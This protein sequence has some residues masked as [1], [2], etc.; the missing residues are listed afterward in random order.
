MYI[1]NF[2][3]VRLANLPTPFDEMA[4]LSRRF[5]GPKLFVKR[6][7]LTGL[8]F[9][10]NKT[11]KLEYVMADAINKRADVIVTGAGIQSNWCTQTIAAAAVI[12][13][14]TVLVPSGPIDGFK[15]RRVWW[16]YTF[17]LHSRCRGQDSRKN[18][19]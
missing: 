3:R 13:L 4:T 16:K 7:D 19:E 9:G 2:P 1:G 12:G 11:R 8:A 15:T 14:K 10:G 18:M 5:G 17:A 6:D